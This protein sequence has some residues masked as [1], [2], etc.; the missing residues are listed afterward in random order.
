MEAQPESD[1]DR[2]VAMGDSCPTCA[3]FIWTGQH[4]KLELIYPKI[5]HVFHEKEL[6]KLQHLSKTQRQEYDYIHMAMKSSYS[7]GERYSCHFPKIIFSM[8]HLKTLQIFDFAFTALPNTFDLLVNVKILHLQNV[9][10]GQIPTSIF[11]MKSL[12]SL[13]LFRCDITEIP[14]D[15]KKLD[16]LSRLNLMDNYCCIPY[17]VCQIKNLE[18]L[19]MENCNIRKIPD[20]ISMLKKL[21]TLDLSFNPIKEISNQFF[22][23]KLEGLNIDDS[24]I[25]YISSMFNKFALK[26]LRLDD[27]CIFDEN[28]NC[29]TELYFTTNYDEQ[30]LCD[31]L[32]DGPQDWRETFSDDE[33]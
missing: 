25:T 20:Y 22:E 28:F 24:N 32:Q 14:S 2:L 11:E 26:Y 17:N 13:T 27:T 29:D 15:I 16:K 5:F 7:T 8:N 10:L 30:K 1:Y 3:T 23:L 6:K 9:S 19:V 18:Q 21:K 4:K 12:K 33:P 31:T